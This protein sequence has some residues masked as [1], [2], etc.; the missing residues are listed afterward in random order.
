[1]RR[2]RLQTW[3]GGGGRGEK[4][5]RVTK[6]FFWQSAFQL[7]FLCKMRLVFSMVGTDSASNKHAVEGRCWHAKRCYLKMTKGTHSRI[8]VGVSRTSWV[9]YGGDRHYCSVAADFRNWYW[10]GPSWSHCAVCHRLFWCLNLPG[11]V[12]TTLFQPEA[13]LAGPCRKQLWHNTPWRQ[14]KK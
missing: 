3:G 9:A 11:K 6:F 12:L 7:F 1:M 10:C 4:S 13:V 5:P 14:E 2:T 8:F